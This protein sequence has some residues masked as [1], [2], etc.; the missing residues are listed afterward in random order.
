MTE[1][2]MREYAQRVIKDRLMQMFTR[3]KDQRREIITAGLEQEVVVVNSTDFTP[4]DTR[5]F[6]GAEVT[7]IEDPETGYSIGP[8]V[9]YCLAEVNSPAMDNLNNGLHGYNQFISNVSAMVAETGQQIWGIGTQPNIGKSL[10]SPSWLVQ[11][12]RYKAMFD[13]QVRHRK[14]NPRMYMTFLPVH[15]KDAKFGKLFEQ[16]HMNALVHAS[17]Q[18]H[19]GFRSL[20]EAF[21]VFNVA[22]RIYPLMTAY[23][24]NSFLYA[25][26]LQRIKASRWGL[27][28]AIRPTIGEMPFGEYDLDSLAKWYVDQVVWLLPDENG[29]LHYCGKP[30]W[31][32]DQADMQREGV[33]RL[34]FAG[35]WP[36][37]RFSL[38]HGTFEIRNQ[39]TP[40]P[41]PPENRGQNIFETLAFWIGLAENIDAVMTFLNFENVKETLNIF[42]DRP[43]LVT[44]EGRRLYRF[45][46][47][48]KYRNLLLELYDLARVGLELRMQE[49]ESLLPTREELT[50]RLKSEHPVV[51]A[52]DPLNRDWSYHE[53]LKQV[54]KIAAF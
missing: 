26:G 16:K 39:C 32:I 38:E 53:R 19:I 49:E 33:I 40:L 17:I 8:E 9:G 29:N 5:L 2:Q 20:E 43:H 1:Q 21:K 51:E 30:F 31:R 47:G 28:N 3:V 13:A 15:L 14:E 48:E 7:K 34:L 35:C 52:Y 6:L 54:S 25:G 36:W 11:K 46:N 24:A 12:P 37:G 23:G 42:V 50:D 41:G 27:W 10:I 4:G 45:Q 44:F 18:P 22:Q